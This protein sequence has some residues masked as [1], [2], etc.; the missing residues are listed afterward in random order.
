MT[1][2][3][4]HSIQTLRTCDITPSVGFL[5]TNYIHVLAP[6]LDPKIGRFKRLLT[7]EILLSIMPLAIVT[8][9]SRGLGRAIALRL[10]DDGMDIAVRLRYDD[11]C[12]PG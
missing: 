7:T 2:R 11:Y 3:V 6:E 8:G 9:A 10:A 4:Q 1:S 12:D 5:N